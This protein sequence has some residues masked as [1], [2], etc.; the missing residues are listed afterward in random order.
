[1]QPGQP[2]TFTLGADPEFTLAVNGMQLH[3]RDALCTL[4]YRRA[5]DSLG[6]DVPGGNLGWDGHASTAE[7]RPLPAHSPKELVENIGKIMR[8]VAE[9]SDGQVSCI[10]SSKFEQVGGHI[11]IGM[12]TNYSAILGK[13]SSVSRGVEKVISRVLGC[14]APLQR[15]TSKETLKKRRAYGQLSDTRAEHRDGVYV[16]E[17][18]APSAEWLT[19]PKIAEATLAYVAM[20]FHE[21]YYHPTSFVVDK[22]EIPSTFYKLEEL[23][24][25]KMEHPNL[26]GRYAQS[27][28]FLIRKFE[29]Y[30]LFKDQIEYIFDY[31][32]V[33]KD[34]EAVNFDVIEGWGLNKRTKNPKVEKDWGE[35]KKELEQPMRLDPLFRNFTIGGHTIKKCD[36]FTNEMA[37]TP[38]N[39]KEVV[40]VVKYAVMKTNFPLKFPVLLFGIKTG[41]DNV[42]PILL[43]C[44]RGRITRIDD[45]PFALST[46]AKNYI[47]DVALPMLDENSFVYALGLPKIWREPMNE[48]MILSTFFKLQRDYDVRSKA[49]TTPESEVA[50]SRHD[51]SF[52]YYTTNNI[53]HQTPMAVTWDDNTSGIAPAI[54]PSAISA[55]EEGLRAE[56]SR[57][58]AELMRQ[59][60]DTHMRTDL[61]SP[62]DS[63]DDPL[64]N[65]TF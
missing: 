37:G 44:Q 29:L 45:T 56:R 14:Y 21:A 9:L 6:F 61:P 20:C 4:A 5:D 3:A 49:R 58:A 18:R 48:E 36:A 1:M 60:I 54:R 40:K 8:K 24:R 52:T 23:D 34:K 35:F 53:W 39:L 15:S 13:N 59:S 33:L 12:P 57:V 26:Y 10:T 17:L 27:I 41:N 19:T 46:L 30:P 47:L 7:I 22:H 28:R 25:L 38:S 42:P 16:V 31:K 65:V 62:S 55:R 11:H 2:L 63:D 50:E 51:P 64:G 32:R 43:R